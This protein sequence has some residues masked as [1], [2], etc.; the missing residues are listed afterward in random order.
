MNDLQESLKDKVKSVQEVNNQ[1]NFEQ[2]R[3]DTAE[4]DEKEKEATELLKNMDD[5]ER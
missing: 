5:F 1:M 4:M 2:H 3:I